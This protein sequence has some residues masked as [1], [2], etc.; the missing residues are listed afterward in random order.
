MPYVYST[1]TAD[2]RYTFYGNGGGDLKIAE[3]D[4]LIKGGTG[5]ANKNLVTPIGVVTKVSDDEAEA[6]RQH[7]VFQMHLANGFVVIENKK[8]DPEKIASDGMVIADDSAPLTEADVK[9]S[10]S[11]KKG[12]SGVTVTTNSE[13]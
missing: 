8:H 4:I 2:N 6:L 12:E 7:P 9:P 11:R 1:L 3:K 13:E 5:I 10:R